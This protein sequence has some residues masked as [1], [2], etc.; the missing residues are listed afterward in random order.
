MRRYFLG[1]L[2][3]WYK[4]T[5]TDAVAQALESSVA[6]DEAAFLRARLQSRRDTRAQA[7]QD[8]RAHATAASDNSANAH[9]SCSSAAPAPAPATPG[10]AGSVSAA[11]AETQASTL[12][13]REHLLAAKAAAQLRANAERELLA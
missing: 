9:A 6:Y 12:S 2:L 11:A 8:M 5:N 13:L 7:T 1:C 3:Y 10:A 4:N